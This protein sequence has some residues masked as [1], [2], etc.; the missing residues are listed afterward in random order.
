MAPIVEVVGLNHSPT[1]QILRSTFLD[2][3]KCHLDLTA[4]TDAIVKYILGFVGGGSINANLFTKVGKNTHLRDQID[5][6]QDRADQMA[7]QVLSIKV[8]LNIVDSI[9]IFLIKTL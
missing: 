2:A 8:S 9:C 6:R 4:Q 3:F 7:E 5:I 1:I